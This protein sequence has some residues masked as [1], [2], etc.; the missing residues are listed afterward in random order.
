MNTLA[1]PCA[2]S[3]SRPNENLRRERFVATLLALAGAAALLEVSLPARPAESQTLQGHV[4]ASVARLHAL[5]RLAG[6]NRLDLVIGLPLRNRPTLDKLIADLYDSASLRYHQYLVP[7]Q[8]AER[9]GPTRQDYEAVIAFA[10]A[11]GLRVTGTH[12]NRTLVD[13]N[14]AAADIEQAFQVKLH[15]FQHPTEQ[16]TF[17]APDAE[18]SLDLSVPLLMVSGLDNFS[19]P[20]PASL[21]LVPL[22]KSSNPAPAVAG[23]GPRGFLMGRDFRA[24]YAS[25]VS[26][27]GA[28]QTVGLLEL[29]GYYT[30]DVLAYEN[31]AGLPNVPLTNVLVNGFSGRPGPANAE[32]A[33]DIDMVISMAPGLSKVI[34]YEGR[35]GSDPYAVLN[36]MATDNQ[37][38]QLSSSWLWAGSSTEAQNQVFLQFAAQGQSFFQASGDDGA[39]CG[40][41]C[42]PWSPADNPNVTVVGGTSLATSSPS[43]AWSS[44]T[45]WSWFPGEAA[46]S[47][48][49]FGTNYTLPAWQQGVDMTGN[50]GSTS[51]R[52]S[53]DVAC[54]ADAIWLVA[55]NGEQFDGAGTSAAAPLWAGF[56]AL[57]NQQAAANGQ[58]GIGFINPAVYAIGK[59]SRYASAF[60]DTTAGN[61]TNTCCG[62]TRFFAGPG[63]DLC[64]GWGTPNGSNLIAALLAPP[65]ALRIM[66]ATPLTFTGPF[67]GP[68]RPAAQ[69]F[70]L[71]NDSNAPLSWTLTGSAPWLNALPTGGTLTNGGPAATVNLTLTATASS[72]PLGSY[73][74]TLWFTNL[75]DRLGQ[76]RLVNLDIV[77]PPVIAS[78]PTN[79]TVFQGMTATFTVALSNSVSC[80]YQWQCDNGL[81]VTNLTDGGNVSGS[82]S[83]TLVIANAAPADAG[84]YSVIV[85]NP[86]GAVSSAEAF[87]AVFPWR[88]VITAPPTSQTVLAGQPVTFTVQA[89][90][91][92]PLFYR[93]QRNGIALTEGGNIS[94]SA[95]SSLT[96]HSASLAD[97]ATYSVIVGNADGLA[98]STGAVLTV[99]AITAPATTLTTLYSFTGGDDGANP[100]ALFRAANGSFYG[101]TQN[102]GTNLA[103]TVFQLAP[104]GT[105]IPLYS[106]TGANDGATPFA[107]LT[108]GPDGNFYGTTYQGGIYDNGTVFRIT[109]SGVLTTL[110]AFNMANGDLPYAGLTLGSDANFY[111]TTYQG[112]ASGRGT[113]VRISTNGALTMLYSFS[114]GAD[115]GH[116]A[117]GLLRGSDGNFYGTTYKGGANSN[118]TVFQ[119]TASGTLKSLASFNN[120]NG[121]FPLAELAQDPTG[122]FYGTT[123]A[124]G[125]SNN[126]AVFRMTPAGLLT[127]LYSFAGGSDGSYPA[128]ALLLGSDGNF[129]GTTAYGGAYGDGTVFRLAPGG[130]LTTL[131]A[132]DGYAGANPQAVL[133]EDADGSLYGT[134]QNG[135]AS[136][137]GVIFRLS[138]S[139][140]PQ[141][142]GQPASQLVYAGETVVLSIAVAGAS[143]FS[144]QWQ[145]NGTNLLDGGNLSGS[146]S[147]FLT[148]T[149]VTT[150]NAGTY[151]VLVNSPAGSTNSATAILQVLSSPPMLVLTPTNQAP[152]ACATVSFNVAAVGNQPLSFRWQKNGVNLTDTCNLSG[153]TS[154]SLVISNVTE[155]DNGTYTVTVTN[156]LG[157][158][159]ASALLTLVPKTASC[160]S[161]TTRHWFGGGADGGPP[162]GLAPGTNGLLYGTTQFG[163]AWN[164]GTVFSLD[165]N[166]VFTTLASFA[167]SNGANPYAAPVQGADGYFYGTTFQGG[168]YNQGTVFV[169]A[170]DGTLTTRYSFTGTGDGANPSA[171][172]V[173][174]GD[175]A[176]YGT[177]AAGGASGYGSVFRFTASGPFSTFT[178]LHSFTGGL[179]GKSPASALVQGA[180]GNFYGL[181]ASGGTSGKGNCFTITPAGALT[182]LHSFT[183]GNDGSSPAGALVLDSDGNFYGTATMSGLGQR[184]TVFRLTPNGA[185]TTIHP[186]GDL[187]LKDGVYPLGGVTQ[188]SD[189]NLYGTTY[190]DYLGGY[191]TVFRVSPDSGTFATLLYFDGCDDGSHPQ[192]ALL[193]DP[194]G[195]LYGTTPAGGPCQTSL[196][197]LFRLSLGCSPQITDQPASQAVVVGTTVQ[198]SVAVSGARPFSYHWQRNGTNLLDA[199]NV[200][201]ATNRSLTLTSVSLANA[202]TYS[203][204]LSNSLGSAAS[205]AAHLTVV[206]PPVFLSAVR[207]NCTLALTWS[208][209]P[210]QRY[211]LQYKS[212]IATTNWTYLGSSVFP[213]SNAVTAADNVCTNTQRFYRV[214]LFPQTQ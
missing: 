61:N 197:T 22:G 51:L 104:A 40:A 212:S 73:A 78:Q 157:A 46:A 121:A 136:D 24:A 115:G 101:T 15:V 210:G 173:Q 96:L 34:V 169:M 93:W 25:G 107:A 195:N 160:T 146:T 56:A 64:T 98:T 214:V 16:R 103:G 82:A 191:G 159:N 1:Q 158:T 185:L 45:V 207:S 123:T 119:I 68:F 3:G 90:G 29:D 203:A 26:L 175:G 190:A 28:G 122:T 62:P 20:R 35:P 141:I 14:G 92:Q 204:N 23:S 17:Y 5:H 84:A 36:R 112:G 41:T 189:G 135:G 145:K 37:A 39:Y 170:A 179:D 66:P 164:L 194:A 47:G 125:A 144:Y 138:F 50:G 54:V 12:P 13:V 126:G 162:N 99:L 196:G 116:V 102:G 206:Y 156:P 168:D 177:T 120:A 163:G 65:T 142:T 132:F 49:G 111:G 202:G 59:S 95:S 88:P 137:Q 106:F 85:S 208:T 182:T 183:G 161:L 205:T 188:S 70:V 38:R 105:V 48:G 133:T 180:D 77:S 154:T 167:G 9:F 176:F 31:L 193:E 149:N 201:G 67:G 150:N 52:N 80:L 74:A 87:L 63:Y 33:L 155:A 7:D 178:N 94:G 44:E 114:N 139:G 165:T 174:G 58:P 110:L 21:R 129:Y 8:F 187:I 209:M 151:S 91:N 72:L 42:F 53:P 43:G 113:A 211:R 30:N 89:V 148:L 143:P 75:N 79:Q 186:F 76:S 199:G 6:T 153:S 124:G 152:N 69:G 213:T 100:N 108:Q 172:L 140:P 198:F 81:S 60:H 147:R 131:V 181:T 4:P 166:G 10:Q 171:A 55:N 57:V 117:A 11:H 27:D 32:I 128:A 19:L 83:S 130:T 200:F 127:T 97:A 109:P 118:G 18:P 2:P 86:A 71:T 192:A 134:T 184:G